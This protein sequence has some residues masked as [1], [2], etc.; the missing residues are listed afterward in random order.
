[1]IFIKKVFCR[2]C[3]YA[4]VDWENNV[5]RCIKNRYQMTGSAGQCKDYKSDKNTD[6][7]NDR[8]MGRM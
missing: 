5:G 6:N 1:M 2:N 3:K 4:Y 8:R 7:D